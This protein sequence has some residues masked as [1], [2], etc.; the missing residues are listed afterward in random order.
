MEKFLRAQKGIPPWMLFTMVIFILSACGEG[1]SA[2]VVPPQDVRPDIFFPGNYECKYERTLSPTGNDLYTIVVEVKNQGTASAESV[3]VIAHSKGPGL[4]G[5]RPPL[6]NNGYYS[7]GIGETVQARFQFIFEKQFSGEYT[8][9]ITADPSNAIYELEE[10]NN[11][12]IFTCN[13]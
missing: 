12:L 11:V 13:F 3:Q 5:D 7:I 6:D 10:F 4:E 1:P 9:T 8:F 2:P